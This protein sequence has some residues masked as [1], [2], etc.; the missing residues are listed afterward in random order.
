MVIDLDYELIS[1]QRID[2]PYFV[3]IHGAGGDKTQWEFQQKFLSNAGFGVLTLS[4][5]G[6]GNSPHTGKPSIDKY[7]KEVEELISQLKIQHYILV[8]H[9]MGGG[10]VLRYALSAFVLPPLTIILIGTGAKLNVA[11][12]FFDLLQSDFKEALRLMGSFSYSSKTD[13]SI[14]LKNQ[15]ILEKNGSKLLTDD[16][17]ACRVFD[18]RKELVDIK[19]PALIIC[20]EEDQ[21]TPPKFA[22]YLH[23]EIQVSHLFIIP[24]AG[25]YVFQEAASEV[26]NIISNEIKRVIDLNGGK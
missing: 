9:S 24:N 21:M 12:V 1:P 18:V 10:I 7:V 15:E 2:Q 19:I 22:E 5:S 3:F 13:T 6:H 16:L 11:P 25:H 4:L 23:N 14:K 20:G 8:G 26:N 17:H